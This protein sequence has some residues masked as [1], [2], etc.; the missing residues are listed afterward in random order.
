MAMR[1]ST[2]TVLVTAIIVAVVLGS[3]A[4]GLVVVALDPSIVVLESVSS[5]LV[6][7]KHSLTVIKHNDTFMVYFV[8][9]FVLTVMKSL[10]PNCNPLQL[11]CYA[12]LVDKHA[13]M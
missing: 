5:L 1:R 7:F 12:S 4:S 9:H 10:L 2:I 3:V 13:I 8:Y 11:A 6:V